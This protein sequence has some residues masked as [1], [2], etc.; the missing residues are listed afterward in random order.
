[1]PLDKTTSEGAFDRNRYHLRTSYRIHSAACPVPVG[2][3][4]AVRAFAS[5]IFTEAFLDEVAHAAEAIPSHSV[6]ALLARRCAVLARVAALL[7][8]DGAHRLPAWEDAHQPTTGVALP[9][10]VQVG[11]QRELAEVKA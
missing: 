3:W 5:G 4:R 6:L 8:C 11:R 10:V 1:L 9:E 2:F 7:K